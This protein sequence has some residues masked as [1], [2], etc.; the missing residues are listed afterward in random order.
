MFKNLILFR[1]ATTWAPNLEATES[2]LRDACFV[3]CGLTQEKSVGWVA[4]RCENG[5]L[6]ECIGG[7]WIMKLMLE[8]K[9]VP[10]AAVSRAVAERCKQIQDTTGRKPGKKEI[11]DLK[12]EARLTL[13]PMA[14]TKQSAVLVWID[15][16]ARLLVIDATSSG[17]ADEV[18]TCL[19]KAM[20]GLGA[21]LLQTTLSPVSAMADWLLSQEPPAGFSIDRECEL[22][23]ADDSKAA[24]RYAHHAL[25]IEEVQQ[26]ISHGKLPTRLALTWEGQVSFVLTDALQIKKVT[27]AEGVLDNSAATS[28][29]GKD[30]RFDADVA[31]AT[32]ELSALIPAL[33]AALGGEVVI[34]TTAAQPVFMGDAEGDPL[35]DQAVALVVKHGKASISLVQRHL[36]IGYNRAARLLERM[37]TDGKVSVMDTAGSR[38]VLAP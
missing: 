3:P 34:S 12:E 14:F 4:P 38:K 10:A 25:D 7:Q 37:E 8:S 23:A 20:D 21:M 22:K 35:Y 18:L 30:D 5:A 17:R 33:L 11:R 15:P 1:L 26:H 19:A 36:K 27:M 16:S 9:A 6:V 2:A 31:I 29:D 13:L 28:G 32:G 24:V